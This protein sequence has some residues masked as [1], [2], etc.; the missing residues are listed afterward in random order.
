MGDPATSK[1]GT[2]AT[3]IMCEQQKYKNR[4]QKKSKICKGVC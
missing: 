2:P 1:A 4:V 3:N